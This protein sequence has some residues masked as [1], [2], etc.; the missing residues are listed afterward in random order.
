VNSDVLT[1]CCE[2][3]NNKSVDGTCP[4]WQADHLYFT[5]WT[6]EVCV[7]LILEAVITQSATCTTSSAVCNC[8]NSNG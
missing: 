5:A 3:S 4:N 1:A 6:T 7:E 2:Y 8:E